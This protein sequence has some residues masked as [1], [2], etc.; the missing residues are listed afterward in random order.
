MTQP[1]HFQ[2][3]NP[4]R[5]A[6]GASSGSDSGSRSRIHLGRAGERSRRSQGWCPR[7]R[8]VAVE[9]GE[10]PSGRPRGRVSWTGCARACW[11]CPE[12]PIVGASS[13]SDSGSRS[14]IHLGRARERSRRSQGWCPRLRSVAVE[15]GEKP[16]VGLLGASRGPACPGAGGQTLRTDRICAV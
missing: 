6:D 15:T 13:G 14:R 4:P 11:W 8:S 3:P 5:T 16:S 10:K 2:E 1:L 9:T 7:L 12:G